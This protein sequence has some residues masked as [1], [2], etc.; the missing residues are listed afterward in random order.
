MDKVKPQ[1]YL[2]IQ[3]WMLD[4]GCSNLREV[5]AYALIYGFSQDNSSQFQGSIPYIQEWLICSSKHTA[6]DTLKSLEDKGLI[7]KEQIEINKVKINRYTA[8]VPD[9]MVG[10]AKIAPVVQNLNQGSAKI[11]PNNNIIINNDNPPLSNDNTPN[12]VESETVEVETIS[13]E[14]LMFDTFRKAYKGTK[15]GLQTEFTNFK[16]KHK[17]WR[18]V[19]PLLLPAYQHQQELREQ[20]KAT[21][22]FV[23]QEKN[24]QTYINQR[25]WEAE[26]HFEPDSRSQQRAQ[27]V[28]PGFVTPEGQARQKRVDEFI[29]ALANS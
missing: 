10:S 13:E 14:E 9:G 17:D 15:R 24:L 8:I 18:E 27:Q 11:A 6:I 1:N 3:G 16:K 29:E 7:K 21:G 28:V 20:G 25:C 5:A 4:L 19:L 12:G 23:P 2:T 22:C 26:E